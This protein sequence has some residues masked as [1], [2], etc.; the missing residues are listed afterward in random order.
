MLGLR[1]DTHAHRR[2][3][4]RLPAQEVLDELG[5]LVQ[6]HVPARSRASY[7]V[8]QSSAKDAALDQPRTQV[9]SS[10][11]SISHSKA[12]KSSGRGRPP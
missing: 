12:M 8:S 7:S 5:Q 2:H 3:G 1:V 6:E 4:G 10:R 11:P 9:P